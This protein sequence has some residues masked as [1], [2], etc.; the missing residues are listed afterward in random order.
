M[1]NS[2]KQLYED[3]LCLLRAVSFHLTGNNNLEEQTA[4]LF[5]RF[6]EHSKIDVAEFQGI[7][8]QGI[9]RDKDLTELNISIYDI[10]L[11][12][13]KLIGV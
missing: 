9:P 2:S 8:F 10:E 5:H 3:C 1:S 4:N 13:E 6:V 12:N 11:D 7:N